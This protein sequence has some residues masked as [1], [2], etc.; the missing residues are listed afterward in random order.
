MIKTFL[1]GLAVLIIL[2]SMLGSVALAYFTGLWLYQHAIFAFWFIGF[3]LFVY[4]VG[5][6][7][8]AYEQNCEEE[9]EE[10]SGMW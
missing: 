6:M 4:F 10:Y 3:L 1:H 5:L 8:E 7:Y 9:D 2:A